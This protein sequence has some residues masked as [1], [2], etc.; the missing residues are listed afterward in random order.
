[1]VLGRRP[2]VLGVTGAM[3][4]GKTTLARAL[5]M[6]PG[7]ALFDCDAIAASIRSRDDVANALRKMYPGA[8]NNDGQLDRR[9][10]AKIIFSDTAEL[11]RV[12]G[13]IHPAINVELSAIIRAAR[14]DILIVENAILFECGMEHLCRATI[15]VLIDEG[16]RLSRLMSKGYSREEIEKRSA[17]QLPQSEK[18]RRAN[19]VVINDGSTVELAARGEA[20]L[21]NLIWNK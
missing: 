20:L 11:R 6:K 14:H 21:C 9:K 5:S 13:L 16:K 4:S 1:M 15:T 18:A 12:E 3:G 19:A 2:F 17:N 7:R 10:L 8:H